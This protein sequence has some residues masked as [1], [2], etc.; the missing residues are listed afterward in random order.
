M[1]IYSDVGSLSLLALT[2]I[3]APS[4]CYQYKMYKIFS[5]T[6][7][8]AFVSLPAPPL[9][10]RQISTRTTLKCTLFTKS[11]PNSK[12]SQ[13]RYSH[14]RCPS[15]QCGQLVTSNPAT[16]IVIPLG[17]GIGPKYRVTDEDIFTN[18]SINNN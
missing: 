4:N 18:L 12:F 8:L 5:M 16:L 14:A 13:P 10:S 7:K 11:S 9:S 15:A 17:L 3:V 2:S 6:I 1:L